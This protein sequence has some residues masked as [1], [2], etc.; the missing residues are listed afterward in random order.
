M[1]QVNPYNALL[2]IDA[3][4]KKF[5]EAGRKDLFRD[6]ASFLEENDPERIFNLCLVH[7]HFSLDPDKIMVADRKQ[8]GNGETYYVTQPE[9]AGSPD[10]KPSAWTVDGFP[11]EWKRTFTGE[12]VADAQALISKFKDTVKGLEVLGLCLAQDPLPDGE[13]WREYLHDKEKQQITK[14]YPRDGPW[15]DGGVYQTSWGVAAES[16]SDPAE[17]ESGSEKAKTTLVFYQNCV[18]IQHAYEPEP[19]PIN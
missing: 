9:L 12:S 6:V 18:C 19:E 4:D 17:V 15:D 14:R 2:L 7:R 16:G 5:T 1:S 11:F 8:D 13:I 10:V 3:A